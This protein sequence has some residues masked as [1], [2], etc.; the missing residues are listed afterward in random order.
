[1]EVGLVFESIYS[2]KEGIFYSYSE[3]VYLNTFWEYIEFLKEMITVKKHVSKILLVILC[4]CLMSTYALALPACP[5]PDC[6]GGIIE[7]TTYDRVKADETA[8]YIVWLI[9]EVTT[10]DCTECSYHDSSRTYV[11][12]DIEPKI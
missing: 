12:K 4:L 7:R 2:Q 3:L 5:N 10:W 8:T 9:Y 1:M 11:G 6:S